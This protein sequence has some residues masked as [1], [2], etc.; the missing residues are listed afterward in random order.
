MNSVDEKKIYKIALVDDQLFQGSGIKE[1]IENYTRTNTIIV[2]TFKYRIHFLKKIMN[3]ENE[4]DLLLT[5]LYED[6]KI[7]DLEIFLRKIRER[8]NEINDSR[9]CRQF[10]KTEHGLAEFPIMIYSNIGHIEDMPKIHKIAIKYSASFIDLRAMAN[11]SGEEF[12]RIILCGLRGYSIFGP[13]KTKTIKKLIPFVADPLKEEWWKFLKDVHELETQT[14]SNMSTKSS[15]SVGTVNNYI[16][17]I[18]DTLLRKKLI[19][20][21]PVKKQRGS[22]NEKKTEDASNKE[23]RTKEKF[24]RILEWYN[25]NCER[26]SRE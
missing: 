23:A 12:Q 19:E 4:Y 17:L 8:E 6:N 15:V 7:L 3:V 16:D 24:W 22:H 5:D 1:L 18:Y 20:K 13:K 14:I 25:R 9:D 11:L 10:W 26:Y 2:D 21:I